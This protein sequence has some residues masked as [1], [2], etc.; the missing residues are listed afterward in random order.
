MTEL[1]IIENVML[2]GVGLTCSSCVPSTVIFFYLIRRRP[3]SSSSYPRLNSC[4]V[5]SNLTSSCRTSGDLIG[6][7][8][9][10]YYLLLRL[11][12]GSTA[13]STTVEFCPALDKTIRSLNANVLLVDISAAGATTD[14][15]CCWI[16]D[17]YRYL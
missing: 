4:D 14:L 8:S 6:V 3:S 5:A 17:R 12:L 7:L 1:E 10:R 15:D 9:R 2:K 11:I 16:L 13:D